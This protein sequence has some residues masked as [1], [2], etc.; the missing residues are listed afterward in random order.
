[1]RIS[2]SLIQSY[3]WDITMGRAAN[4]DDPMQDLRGY[5]AEIDR[6]GER[7]TED[8]NDEWLMLAINSLLADP[9]GRVQPFVGQGYPFDERQMVSLLRYAF[10][11]LWPDMLPSEE[12]SPTRI[13]IEPMSDEDWA[14]LSADS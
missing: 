5:D 14:L 12:G 6:M 8:G 1:M 9:E 10:E 4:R 2:Q 3:L 13:T 11:R 7:A